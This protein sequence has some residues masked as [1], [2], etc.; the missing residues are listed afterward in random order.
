MYLK[1]KNK[2]EC[3]GCTACQQVCGKSAITMQTDEEGF[4]YPQTDESLCINC[5]LCEKVCAFS[6]PVYNNEETPDVYATHL[7]D[8]EQREKSSSGGL[9]YTIAKWIISQGG[10]VYGAAFDKNLTLRHIGVETENDLQAL[11]GSK[12]LQSDLRNTYKEAREELKKGRWCYFTGTACQ[13][14][15]LKAFLRKDYPTL[16]TSDLVCH[17]VPSQKIFN[18]HLAYLRK[19]HNNNN[20]TNYQFRDNKKWGV[21]EIVNFTNPNKQEIVYTKPTYE[22]S[23]YLYSFMHSYTYRY[24]CYDCKFA[25]I[26]RQGDIT[27]ADYWGA[28]TFFPD[29]DMSCGVSL[30]LLNNEK[31]KNFW[32]NIK[33]ECKYYKSNVTDAAKYN[34]NLIHKTKEPEIRKS[35]YRLIE[36]EGYEKI[37]K[38]EFRHKNYYRI[39]VKAKLSDTYIYKLLKTIFKH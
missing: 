15:G 36:K 33:E 2:Y 21:C 24:S 29:I 18:E 37:A 13:I 32:N 23:P 7:T 8:R 35:I 20:I 30:I 1:T 14:A 17:G 11:R 27:L 28:K 34:A 31:G 12:Y 26:P 4:A 3:C 10:I 22:L 16:I 19:K 25:K 9:F 38:R 5:G 39:L 6:S